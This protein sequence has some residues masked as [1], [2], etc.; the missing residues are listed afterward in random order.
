MNGLISDGLSHLSAWAQNGSD[1]L[2]KRR[3]VKRPDLMDRVL[4][5]LAMGLLMLVWWWRS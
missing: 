1:W 4:L 5:G 2:N 3:S